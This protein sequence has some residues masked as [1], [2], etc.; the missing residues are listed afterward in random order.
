MNPRIEKLLKL[1]LYQRGLILG[2]LLLIIVGAFVYFLYLPQQEE[3][4]SLV[5]RSDQLEAKLLEDR[6]IANNLPKFKAEYEKMQAKLK[7]ALKE[8]PNEKEIPTLLTSIASLAKDNGLEVLTFRPGG[9]IPKGFYAEVPVSLKLAG[10]YHEV[11]LFVQAVGSLPRIV[12]IGDLSLGGPNVQDGRTQLSIDCL[13]TTFRFL[14]G[15]VEPPKK[16]R[17]G[18]RT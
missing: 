13:A 14:E 4:Q 3:Y 2:V 10:S 5:A 18:G 8:L 1:P 7:E 17:G 6:R 9:E 15:S 16:P 11:A 12:N